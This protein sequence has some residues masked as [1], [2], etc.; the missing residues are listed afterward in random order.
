MSS[1]KELESFKV[2]SACDLALN[3]IKDKENEH[4]KEIVEHE[5]A[6]D[7]KRWFPRNKTDDQIIYEYKQED[8][9]LYF[10]LEYYYYGDIIKLKNLCSTNPLSNVS[11]SSD[12]F[13]LINNF[14]VK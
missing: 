7:A 3:H 4:L 10:R 6:R 9:W 14:Y 11:I 8:D 5:K 2:I 13:N 12:Y 1:F